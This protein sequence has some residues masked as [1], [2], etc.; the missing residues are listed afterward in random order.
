[1]IAWIVTAIMAA[2]VCYSVL[3][4]PLQVTDSLIPMLDAQ[5][6]SSVI[7]AFAS[8]ATNAGYFRPLRAAQI[9]ALFELSNGHYFA[10]YKGFQA[11]TVLVVFVLFLAV[12]EIDSRQRAAALLFALTV[13]M[14]LHTFRGTVWEAYPVNHSL[15]VVAFCLLALLLAR[16]AGGRWTD[17][18]AALTFI[19]ATFTV[20]SGLLVWVVIAAAWL[21][22]ARGISRRGV[23]II[24]VLLAVS[25]A[26][27][28]GYLRTGVPTLSERSSGFGLRQ[29]DPAE[30]QRRFGAWPYGFYAYSVLS[31]RLTVLFSKPRA[32]IW[33]TAAEFARGRVAA[34]TIVN[35]VSSTVTTAVMGWFV[36]ARRG[37]WTRRAFDRDDQIVLVSLAVIVA[38]AVISYGY[39][40]DE[41]MGPAGVFYALAAC[42]SVAVLLSRPFQPASG[43]LALILAMT[44]SG[45]VVRT[46]GLHYQMNLMTFYDRNEWVY[47]DDWLVE[48][49]SA[50]ATEAGKAL[51]PQLCRRWPER[52]AGEP[53]FPPPPAGQCFP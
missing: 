2:T 53:A 22:G 41:I 24:T 26:M 45:W 31:S 30:L 48:Q 42:V 37:A 39:T 4:I 32:G 5:R 49:K 12:L 33:T 18:A 36:V 7:G 21:T 51:R 38:N 29:L 1:M 19:A 25:L 8:G 16:S 34:G 17:A 23:I 10:A 40:K 3:R 14:G 46:A 11:A 50:P 35:I 9:Q 20:E 15:E 13:L 52:A 44:A 27:R 47:V 43:A 6:S 28:F